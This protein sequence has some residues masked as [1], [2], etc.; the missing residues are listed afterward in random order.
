MNNSSTYFVIGVLA[1]FVVLTSVAW[2][3]YRR[4]RRSSRV[5]WEDLVQR[6]IWVD[7]K[8]VEQIALDL[9]NHSGQIDDNRDQE[10]IDPARI[11]GMIGGLKGLEDLQT[12]GQVMI[13]MATLLQRS[14]PE[15]LLVAEELRLYAR[16]LDWHIGRLEGAAKTGNLEISF[17]F[18]AKRAIATYYRMSRQLLALYQE[19][20]LS[21]FS[22]LEKAL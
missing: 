3:F 1:L 16:E 19:K 18:Y 13:E 21:V 15:A 7:P 5:S 11:F 17:P 10:R 2:H 12:N 8:V 4:S 20:N 6:L 9:L 14:Y 22:Q